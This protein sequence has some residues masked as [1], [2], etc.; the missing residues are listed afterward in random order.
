MIKKT[1][2]KKVNEKKPKSGLLL[3][4]KKLKEVRTKFET[5]MSDGGGTGVSDNNDNSSGNNLI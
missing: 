3:D 5:S 1:K 4:S 2:E